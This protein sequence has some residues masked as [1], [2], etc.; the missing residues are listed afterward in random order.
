MRSH[1]GVLTMY[2]VRSEME[3]KDALSQVLNLIDPTIDSIDFNGLFQV[4]TAF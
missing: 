3:E 2:E 1:S 4:L